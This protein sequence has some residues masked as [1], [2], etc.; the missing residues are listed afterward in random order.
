MLLPLRLLRLH[1][2]VALVVHPTAKAHLAVV[3]VAKVHL[4]AATKAAAAAAV[5][6]AAAA[7][8]VLKVAEAA[9]AL[10]LLEAVKVAKAVPV[11]EE[12]VEQVPV[13]KVAL[14]VKVGAKAAAMVV[15]ETVA[16]VEK[17]VAV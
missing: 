15:G 11:L 3:L 10:D 17:S 8:E 14:A 1:L 5:V 9:L 2:M 16:V 6:A 7:K 4:A 12:R 13:V